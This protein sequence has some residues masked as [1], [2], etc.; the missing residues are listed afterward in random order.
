[1]HGCK[2]ELCM[3]VRARCAWVCGRGVGG[4]EGEVC[5]DKKHVSSGGISEGERW[6]CERER[7]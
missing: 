6:A 7:C 4:C 1:M 5:M 2:G 3:G